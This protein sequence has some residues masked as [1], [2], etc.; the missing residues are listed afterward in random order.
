MILQ[1]SSGGAYEIYYNEQIIF[2]KLKEGRYPGIGE[3]ESLV[4][5]FVI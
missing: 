5:N 3:I 2:S 1:P 4:R